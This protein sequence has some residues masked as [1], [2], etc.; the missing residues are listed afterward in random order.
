MVETK[1]DG[2]RYK[3]FIPFSL[4]LFYALGGEYGSPKHEKELKTHKLFMR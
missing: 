4:D 3:L 1:G 2:K